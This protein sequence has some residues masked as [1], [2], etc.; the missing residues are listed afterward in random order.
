[1]SQLVKFNSTPSL[2]S[3]FE[4]FW[5]NDLV[6]YDMLSKA[7]LPAVNVKDKDKEYEI[8][9]A[10]PGFKKEDFSISVENRILTISAEENEE[11]EVKEDKYTRRE[12]LSSSFTRSFSL[13]ENIDESQIRGHYVDGVLCVTIPKVQEKVL[14]KKKIPLN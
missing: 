12:F 14:E 7:K 2:L 4:N 6:N 13:P 8:E 1:M 11:K 5:G 3:V 10:A 9:V